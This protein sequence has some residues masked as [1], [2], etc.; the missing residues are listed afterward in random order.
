[1]SGIDENNVTTSLSYPQVFENNDMDDG[2]IIKR[3]KF[4]SKE[5]VDELKDWV[6]D[7]FDA[8]EAF[9]EIDRAGNGKLTFDEVTK[10][11]MMKN[12]KIEVEKQKQK[13]RE[14]ED[15]EE[16]TEN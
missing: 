12:V 15:E 14:A 8:S 4:I 5:V 9:T 6:G 10:W 3:S 11:A 1:M 13:E 16:E 7:D 2:H